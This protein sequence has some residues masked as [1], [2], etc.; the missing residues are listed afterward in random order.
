MKLRLEDGENEMTKWPINCLSVLFRATLIAL[1]L[2]AVAHPRHA[3]PIETT[4]QHSDQ[5]KKVRV[6]GVEL[7]YLE[8]GKG[9]RDNSANRSTQTSGRTGAL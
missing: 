5:P 3:Q 7:N 8:R 6:N 4:R 9:A 2:L 1:V